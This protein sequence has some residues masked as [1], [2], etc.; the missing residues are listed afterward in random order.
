MRTRALAAPQ[1]PFASALS[2]LISFLVPLPPLL[3]G[4]ASQTAL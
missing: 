4:A 2:E 1:M 3:R